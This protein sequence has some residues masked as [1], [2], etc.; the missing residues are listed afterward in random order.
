M[1]NWLKS[2]CSNKILLDIDLNQ[3]KESFLWS[4]YPNFI[5]E[6]FFKIAIKQKQKQ[7][8]NSGLDVPKKNKYILVFSILMNLR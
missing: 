7:F 1:V 3:L 4:D 8:Q 2:I 6:K 5:I